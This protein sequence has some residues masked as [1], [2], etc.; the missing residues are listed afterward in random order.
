MERSIRKTANKFICYKTIKIL[1]YGVIM[2]GISGEGED[3]M[4]GVKSYPAVLY[5]YKLR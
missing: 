1:N 5:L 3:I 4:A 2:G